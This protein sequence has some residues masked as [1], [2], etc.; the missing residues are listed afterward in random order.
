VQCSR[1]TS[2]APLEGVRRSGVGA[3]REVALGCLSTGGLG[4]FTMRFGVSLGGFRGMVRRMMMMAVGDVRV[5]RGEVMIFFFVMLRG[6]AMMTG[7]VLM[8]LGSLV[9]M[10]DCMLG[11][12]SSSRV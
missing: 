6:F 9:V 11:H 4:G 10:L 2:A 5:M 12:V 8:M 3:L 7:R 1:H